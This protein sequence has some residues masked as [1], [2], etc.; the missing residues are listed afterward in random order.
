MMGVEHHLKDHA[1]GI[2]TGAMDSLANV[3]EIVNMPT[4]P[5]HPQDSD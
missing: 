4:N 5:Y 1:A 2:S 3:V